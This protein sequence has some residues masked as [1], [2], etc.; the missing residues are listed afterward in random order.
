MP[1]RYDYLL[2]GAALIDINAE[3]EDLEKVDTKKE[4]LICL[5]LAS[6]TNL[7]SEK[8]NTGGSALNVGITL[9]CLGARSALVTCIGQD[10][11]GDYIIRR[12]DD[13]NINKSFVYRKNKSTGIG[14]NILSAGEK[15][16]LVFHGAVDELSEDDITQTMIKESK[17]ILITSISSQKNFRAFKKILRLAKKFDVPVIFAPSMTMI[18][19]NIA[20]LKKLRF[21]FDIAI[22][23]YEEG[24]AITGK[25]EIKQI[26]DKLN[27]NTCVITKDKEGAFAKHGKEY[28]QVNSLP[29]K[30]KN[31][32]GAGDVFCGSFVHTFYT[33]KSLKEALRIATTVA[34]MKLATMESEVM[35]FPPEIL[36]FLKVYE[37]K[38]KIKELK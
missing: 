34:G 30:I 28:L 35:C 37:K 10:I 16:S 8:T 38:I 4:H 32:T 5:D 33:K 24:I 6:K 23:N 20:D 29:V 19:K 11:F 18:R 1:K 25:K 14:I 2:I 36:K 21:K 26:L 12:L 13:S 17:H 22:M 9:D 7:D 3:T 15:S 31:T 27:A